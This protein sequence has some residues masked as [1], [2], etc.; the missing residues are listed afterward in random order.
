MAKVAAAPVPIR[1]SSPSTKPVVV[2]AR[3]PKSNLSFSVDQAKLLIVDNW[4]TV[5]RFK[6]IRGPRIT[7]SRF[8]VNVGEQIYSM[9]PDGSDQVNISNSPGQEDETPAISPRDG[10]VV[11][12]RGGGYSGALYTMASDGSGPS[13]LPPPPAGSFDVQ[14]AWSHNGQHI[15]FNR[16]YQIWIANADGTGAKPLMDYSQPPYALDHA[17]SWSPDGKQIAFWRERGG[18][19]AIMKVNVAPGSSPT[20]ITDGSYYDGFP[21]F[22]PDGAR[23]AFWRNDGNQGA[24]WTIS[25]D[26]QGQATNVSKPD[27]PHGVMDYIPFWSPDGAEIAFSR[28]S[29]VNWD[30][31]IMSNDG[32]NQRNV[33]KGPGGHCDFYAN[34]QNYA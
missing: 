7:F 19:S 11:F 8:L 32:S 5:I 25:A 4:N 27:S 18:S 2:P 22:S 14:P 10:H 20:N 15:A 30:I 13:A 6:L 3:N 17:P 23:I 12:S 29:Y 16:F 24:I 31:W 33:S 34:W 28:T 21:V 9:N 1:K 26:G